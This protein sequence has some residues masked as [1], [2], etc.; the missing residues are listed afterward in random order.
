M[1]DLPPS[2]TDLWDEAA[3]AVKN[4]QGKWVLIGDGARRPRNEKAREALARRGLTVEVTSR[5][6]GGPTSKNRNW[7]GWRT[8][9]RTV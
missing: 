6:G 1:T 8:W 5:F 7:T 3:E 4:G 2:A 9:A